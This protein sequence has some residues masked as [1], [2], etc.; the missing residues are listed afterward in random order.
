MMMQR[1]NVSACVAGFSKF[2]AQ[3]AQWNRFFLTELGIVFAE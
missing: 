3:S 2:P 1:S